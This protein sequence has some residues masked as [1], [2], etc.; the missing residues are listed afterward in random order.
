MTS[1]AQVEMH[2]PV[3]EELLF[4]GAASARPHRR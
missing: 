3:L 2:G 4:S 1:F